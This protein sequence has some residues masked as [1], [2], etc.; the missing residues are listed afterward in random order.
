MSSVIQATHATGVDRVLASQHY[1]KRTD[2]TFE[3]RATPL[4]GC[5]TSTILDIYCSMKQLHDTQ[6]GWLVVMRDLGELMALA[7]DNG[8]DESLRT[9]LREEGV[10]VRIPRRGPDL[11]RS[12]GN[13]LT[14]IGRI[15][16]ARTLRQRFSDYCAGT[17][18]L[19]G[20]EPCSANS[21]HLS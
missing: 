1:A 11:R 6:V 9:K 8:Y 16:A 19:C 12:T 10:T 17:E 15:T 13:L 4:I 21:V 5:E 2:Y 20:R 7:A 3:T 14:L 18:R